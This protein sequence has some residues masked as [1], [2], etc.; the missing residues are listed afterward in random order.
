MAEY[1]KHTGGSVA[2][3]SK[4]PYDAMVYQDAN[5]GYTIAV[6]GDG[7]VIKKVLT[8][9]STD[10]V[11]IQAAIDNANDIYIGSGLFQISSTLS[12]LSPGGVKITGSG[13]S[14]QGTILY[15]KDSSDCDVLKLYRDSTA[16][17]PCIIR[18]IRIDGNKNNNASGNGILL[19]GGTSTL[20]GTTIDGVI[21]NYAK[22]SGIK[23]YKGFSTN[24]SNSQSEANGTDGILIQSSS[25]IFCNKIFAERND[26]GLNLI[27]SKNC[28]IRDYEFDYPTTTGVMID[29]S[30]YSNIFDGL[31]CKILNTSSVAICIDIDGYH[32]T[33]TNCTLNI[34]SN[35]K[36]LD[37]GSNGNVVTN[38]VFSTDTSDTNDYGIYCTGSHNAFDNIRINKSDTSIY[39]SGDRNVFTKIYTTNYSTLI[40]NTGVKNRF[41]DFTY[42]E[43]N[44]FGTAA[45]VAAGNTYVD[46]AHGL[47]FAPTTV[48]ATPT[49][50]LGTRSFWVDTKGASTFRININS[51]DVIDHTFDWEAEV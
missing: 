32:N 22:E 51:S 34:R 42:R 27:A 12:V 2:G 30:S 21:I 23:I 28:N 38:S 14:N 16:W 33:L 43:V 35:T 37:I 48:R 11:V 6:D 13:N 3:K 15:L 5:T 19:D 45:T 49:T 20:W 1:I 24:I 40:D 25:S 7:N 31:S 9:L 4:Q 29:S 26:V 41:A 39:V 36:V 44:S 17:V 8:A 50:N 10:D 47:A 18:D 46:V